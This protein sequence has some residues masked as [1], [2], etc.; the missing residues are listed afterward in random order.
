M[1]LNLELQPVGSFDPGGERSDAAANRKLLL[2]T[3]RRL[4]AA[5]GVPAVTMADIAREAG[6]GK[7]TLYRRFANKGQLCYAL[8]DQGLQDFQ[9]GVLRQLRQMAAEG[10]PALKQLDSFLDALVHYTVE[11]LPYLCEVGQADIGPAE[12]F[13]LPHRWQM[14]T[15]RVLL[16]E[17][18]ERGEAR[19]D[20][21]VDMIAALLVGPLNALV[22]RAY[23]EG[24]GF[25]VERVS[26]G[27]RTLV[28]GLAAPPVS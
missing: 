25:E 26:A 4:F 24:L 11:F 13:N 7:G 19:A 5:H 21:D 10:M 23:L 15:I 6:V 2:Q 1:N 17:A 16:S 12:R 28:A 27:L 9:N 18:V 8:L 20:L 3:A 22:L 14:L